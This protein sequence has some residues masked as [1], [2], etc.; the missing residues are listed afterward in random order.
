VRLL[1]VGEASKGEHERGGDEFAEHEFVFAVEKEEG[2]EVK[3]GCKLLKIGLRIVNLRQQFV[4]LIVWR[5]EFV[6]SFELPLH[7]L[8]QDVLQQKLQFAG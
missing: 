3:N 5:L 2:V 4:Q 7:R 6:I 1:G 8:L